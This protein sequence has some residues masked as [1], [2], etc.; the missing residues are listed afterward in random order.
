MGMTRGIGRFRQIDEN[1]LSGALPKQHRAAPAWR[2]R[3]CPCID[4][5]PR[6]CVARDRCRAGARR[7]SNGIRE[8]LSV[9]GLQPT[10]RICSPGRPPCLEV[11]CSR[12]T[13]MTS[14]RPRQTAFERRAL[15]SCESRGSAIRSPPTLD[16]AAPAPLGSGPR[17]RSTW[18]ATNSV[19]VVADARLVFARSWCPGTPGGIE[20]RRLAQRLRS[21]DCPRI[22]L[23]RRARMHEAHDEKERR[24]P[25]PHLPAS[26]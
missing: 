2:V 14:L 11:A 5:G 9:P 1:S 26:G 12:S 19:V 3:N 8:G 10:N 23:R 22:D 18:V 7:D 24:C 20:D 16:T 25:S 4:P 21:G 15:G 6:A 17:L 13:R